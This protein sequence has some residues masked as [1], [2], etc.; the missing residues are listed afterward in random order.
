MTTRNIDFFCSNTMNMKFNELHSSSWFMVAYIIIVKMYLWDHIIIKT[1]YK[2]LNYCLLPWNFASF[3]QKLLLTFVSLLKAH[4]IKYICIHFNTVLTFQTMF[5]FI[6]NKTYYFKLKII[7]CP[8]TYTVYQWMC[9][10][11]KRTIFCL[12]A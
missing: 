8:S 12:F 5:Y 4:A 6:L 11:F 10:P 9:V 7:S 1:N 3:F 2:T